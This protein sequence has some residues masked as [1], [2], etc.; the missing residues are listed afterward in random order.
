MKKISNIIKL[1]MLQIILSFIFTSPA[2]AILNTYIDLEKGVI[3]VYSYVEASVNAEGV[4]IYFRCKSKSCKTTAEAFADC[5]TQMDSTVTAINSLGL[6]VENI[7]KVSAKLYFEKKLAYNIPDVSD[8]PSTPSGN[9]P[10]ETINVVSVQDIK[11]TISNKDKDKDKYFKDVILIEDAMLKRGL[12][13]IEHSDYGQKPFAFMESWLGS[14]DNT[15]LFIRDTKQLESEALK[16]AI[17]QAKVK[18]DEIAKNLN[19]VIT[20]VYSIQYIDEKDK[21]IHIL[22]SFR[23]SSFNEPVEYSDT[24]K[25]RIGIIV[26]FSFE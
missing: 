22:N 6:N 25:Y 13:P 10:K 1:F 21:I 9:Q 18:A 15:E 11:I 3:S 4:N 26:N 23:P 2:K 12:L 8:I 24:L 19:K 7:E 16:K 20:G 17:D 14:K 5:T